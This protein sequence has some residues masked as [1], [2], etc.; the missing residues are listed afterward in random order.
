[1]TTLT[2]PSCQ[3]FASNIS[4]EDQGVS[5]IAH[6]TRSAAQP[7]TQTASR[8]ATVS[9]LLSP[10]YHTRLSLYVSSTGAKK[11]PGLTKILTFALIRRLTN[12]NSP[13]QH[14][15]YVCTLCSECRSYVCSLGC[16]D[17][18]QHVARTLSRAHGGNCFL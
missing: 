15:R 1:M 3:P 16:T 8:S 4:G 5:A 10:S 14:L 18:R 12:P 2:S 13:Y 11:L 9:V 17:P 7:S 6:Q